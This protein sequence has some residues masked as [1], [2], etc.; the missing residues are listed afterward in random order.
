MFGEVISGVISKN[1]III[2]KSFY[3]EC[4]AKV[5]CIEKD[6]NLLECASRGDN[7]GILIEETNISEF[8]CIKG[9]AYARKK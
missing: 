5:L 6:R 3:G 1:D 7:I 8:D 9:Y 4:E 2:V